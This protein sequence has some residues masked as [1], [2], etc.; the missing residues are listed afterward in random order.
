MVDAFEIKD[1]TLI[2]IGTGEGAQ[3][4]RELRDRLQTIHPGCI[5]YHFWGGMLRVRFED[6]EYPNDFAAWVRYEIHD[7]TL[8]ERLAVIDPSEYEDLENLR[9]ELVEVI[10]ERLEES[11]LTSRLI[12]EQKLYFVRSQI[13][14]FDTGIRLHNPEELRKTIPCL[15]SGSIFYH[16]IDARRRIGQRNNDF[17]EWLKHF[18]DTYVLVA[19]KIA[20][21]DPYFT[22]LTALRAE[23]EA[24]FF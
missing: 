10:E 23:I 22:T 3:D 20:L 16:F 2:A 6:P 14:V 1:C 17:S 11:E 13:I 12:A 4:L 18:G 19:Q 8:S 24:A 5:Y 21:I 7:K 9:R 15:T